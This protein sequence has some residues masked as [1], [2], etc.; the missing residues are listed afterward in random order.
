MKLRRHV[1]GEHIL[2]IE[3]LLCDAQRLCRFVLLHHTVLCYNSRSGLRSNALSAQKRAGYKA[4]ESGLF[5]GITLSRRESRSCE[6]AGKRRS[7]CSYAVIAAVGVPSTPA[8]Q[9]RADFILQNRCYECYRIVRTEF[10]GLMLAQPTNKPQCGLQQYYP[11]LSAQAAKPPK[12]ACFRGSS[13]PAG[14]VPA[15]AAMLYVFF[16]LSP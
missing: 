7:A 5:Q 1:G 14:K 10:S 13:F 9:S 4:S 2:G 12:A 11:I 3:M 16:P 6:A 15:L 8:R